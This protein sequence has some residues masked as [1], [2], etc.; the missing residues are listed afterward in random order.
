MSDTNIKAILKALIGKVE[1]LEASQ[2]AAI[3]F[4]LELSKGKA[5]SSDVQRA[6]EKAKSLNKKSFD[7]LRKAADE[8]SFTPF[9]R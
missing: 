2:A 7:D 3:A 1:D 6:I 4:L 8:I 5:S 9:S